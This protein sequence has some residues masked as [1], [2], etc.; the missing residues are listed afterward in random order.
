MPFHKIG[1]ILLAVAVAGLAHV[2]A[3]AAVIYVLTEVLRLGDV[4][5]G[6]RGFELYWPLWTVFFLPVVLCATVAWLRAPSTPLLLGFAAIIYLAMS[7]S[8][9]FDSPWWTLMIEWVV[10]G[11]AFFLIAAAA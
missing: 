5:F 11:I 3:T 10:L 9:Y 8:L 1:L 2:A 4:K 7:A 6:G